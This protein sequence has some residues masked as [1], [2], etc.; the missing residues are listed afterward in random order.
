M[1][2]FIISML[3]SAY[4]Q[5]P[6]LALVFSLSCVQP[7]DIGID[8]NGTQQLVVEGSVNDADEVVT[9]RL[10]T[11]GSFEG[12][13]VNTLGVN[14]QVQIVSGA[15]EITHLNE[16]SP[17]LYRTDTAA[18]LGQ[19]GESYTLRIQLANGESYTS[20]ME[21]IPQPVN[22]SQGRAE[23]LETRG[24][25][26]DRIPFVEYSHN[27][28][29]KLENTSENHFV[30]VTAAGWARV[31]VDYPL[32]GGFDGGS[33][34]PPGPQIC[35]SRRNPITSQVNT[36]TNQA[37]TGS[38]YEVLADNVPFDFRDAYVAD[39]F[40]NAMSP[41]A[42]AYWELAKLQIERAGGLF[43]PPFAPVV[44]NIRNV[45]DPD[46]VVLGY[47]H[48]YARTSTRVC[49]DRA[50]TPAFVNIP[51]LDCLTTCTQFFRPAVFELPFD[52]ED[53]CPDLE[54]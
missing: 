28:Y 24:V 51:I 6:V 25:S 54:R 44:G 17:G 53:S 40:A 47:F 13:S 52:L 22:I 46:E 29:A 12:V 50:G 36:V 7:F 21:T 11:S 43:D 4:M 16:I 15:D 35:W 32:C 41:E 18:L 8:V 39:L 37:V 10:R 3:R 33:T 48:A 38:E 26:D 45:N 49:F 27:V 5:L 42:F 9:V 20:T 31:Q 14:A 2:S 30:R 1:R 23:A 19:V 34:G